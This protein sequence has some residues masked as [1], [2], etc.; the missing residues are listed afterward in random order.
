MVAVA[1][2]GRNANVRPAALRCPFAGPTVGPTRSAVL[3]AEQL[4]ADG[5]AASEF[6]LKAVRIRSK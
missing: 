3:W 4:T 2:P 5:R 6:A 1:D